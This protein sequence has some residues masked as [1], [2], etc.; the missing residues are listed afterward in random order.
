MRKRFTASACTR[1]SRYGFIV[2]EFPS[3]DLTVGWTD[4]RL[5]QP[6]IVSDRVGG[7]ERLSLGE[8]KLE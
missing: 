7:K 3:P 4:R 6:C 1:Y 2:G 5:V 8:K